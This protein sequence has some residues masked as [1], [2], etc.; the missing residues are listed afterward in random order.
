MSSSWI[1]HPTPARGDALPALGTELNAYSERHRMG[2]LT[3][4]VA[5]PASGACSDARPSEANRDVIAP[6]AV[7]A[8]T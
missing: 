8:G 2:C 3:R 1:L 7:T 4:G 6:A 5:P